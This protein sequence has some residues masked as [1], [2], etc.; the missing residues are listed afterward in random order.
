MQTGGKRIGTE[1]M[2][3]TKRYSVQCIQEQKEQW[4]SAGLCKDIVLENL[5]RSKW[6]IVFVQLIQ[7]N[8]GYS[9][10]PQKCSQ[11]LGTLT[12]QIFHFYKKKFRN[13]QRGQNYRLLLFQNKALIG[14][15]L[16][17]KIKISH[18]LS[19]LSIWLN[20]K[21]WRIIEVPLYRRNKDMQKINTVVVI[22]NVGFIAV[23]VV[24]AVHSSRWL[25]LS[26][27]P[28]PLLSICCLLFPAHFSHHLKFSQ[29]DFTFYL[30]HSLSFFVVRLSYS[31]YLLRLCYV[32]CILPATNALTFFT[33]SCSCSCCCRYWVFLCF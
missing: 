31:T 11:I 27:S 18:N 17:A 15:D 20:V 13:K 21:A 6:K 29:N 14:K 19:Y 7:W 22:V 5:H 16:N 8:A 25:T 32:S 28:P 9:S 26:F 1:Q 24:F 12:D 2:K 23:V 33:F 4:V 30:S 3:H 10:P